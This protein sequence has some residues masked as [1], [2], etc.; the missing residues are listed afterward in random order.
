MDARK[1]T[2]LNLNLSSDEM[3]LL[4]AV[5]PPRQMN[6]FIVSA[7]VERARQ[8]ERERLRRQIVEAYEAD[9]EFQ[10][11]AGAEWDELSTTGWPEA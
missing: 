7:A 11:Q 6:R 4:R 10:R 8:V 3:E 9:P 2:R 5:V 1:K